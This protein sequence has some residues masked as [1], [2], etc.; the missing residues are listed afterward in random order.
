MEKY[1]LKSR[2]IMKIILIYHT[3]MV[4]TQWKKIGKESRMCGIYVH[5][6]RKKTKIPRQGSL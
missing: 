6:S 3:V 2:E 1:I 5:V 4:S